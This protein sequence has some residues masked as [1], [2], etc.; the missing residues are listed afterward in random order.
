MDGP[1]KA[2]PIALAPDA[3]TREAFLVVVGACLAHADA[4]AAGVDAEG[5]P[6]AL[7][8]LRVAYRRLRSAF[9]LHRKVCRDD[10]RARALTERLRALTAAFGPAR[11]LD[12]FLAAHRDLDEGAVARV[13]QLRVDAYGTAVQAVRAPELPAWRAEL[14]AW[15]DIAWLG[16]EHP[17]SAR[18]SASAALTL[19]RDRIARRGRDLVA[20]TPA[21]RHRVR[22]EAKK[23][24]YGCQFYGSLWPG[25]EASVWAYEQALAT[26]QDQL[27]LL[28]DVAVWSAIRADAGIA[29]PEPPVDVPRTL[30]A[31]QITWHGVVGSPMFW[32]PTGGRRRSVP[33]R[34]ARMTP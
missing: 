6:E 33:A 16:S 19:R 4:N 23:L 32:R 22:I 20:L 14:Q 21:R 5:D 11:D 2:P 26:L 10:P 30:A 7:H 9:S 29:T 13:R 24:R 27:G 17:G 25:R 18:R 31:A 34:G 3:S 28:N 1:A 8:Q 12:V 15:L